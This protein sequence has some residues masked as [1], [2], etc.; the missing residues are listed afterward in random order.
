MFGR[1]DT[2]RAS[3]APTSEARAV[4]AGVRVRLLHDHRGFSGIPAALGSFG[5]STSHCV[6]AG[7]DRCVALLGGLLGN[8]ALTIAS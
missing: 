8:E 2:D 7:P 3:L 5:I 6:Q 4:V 1:A